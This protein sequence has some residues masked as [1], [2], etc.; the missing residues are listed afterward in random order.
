MWLSVLLSWVLSG[1]NAPGPYRG[2]PTFRRWASISRVRPAWRRT[3]LCC[4]TSPSSRPSDTSTRVATFSLN[5]CEPAFSCAKTRD[6]AGLPTWSIATGGAPYARLLVLSTP[7][8]CESLVNTAIRRSTATAWMRPTASNT[9]LCSPRKSVRHWSGQPAISTWVSASVGSLMTDGGIQGRVS[10]R[11]SLGPGDCATLPVLLSK[12][13]QVSSW[14]TEVLPR[15]I[16]G[17]R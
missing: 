9:G 6:A 14:W 3:R 7:R 12:R 16:R 4:A 13:F 5:S 2:R 8:S 11:W 10:Q 17:R 15:L 1:S